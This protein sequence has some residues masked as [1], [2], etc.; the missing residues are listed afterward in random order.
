MEDGS[1]QQLLAALGGD[2]AQGFLIAEPMPLSALIEWL[3]TS[4]EDFVDQSEVST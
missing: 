4:A 3:R 2:Q 1:T